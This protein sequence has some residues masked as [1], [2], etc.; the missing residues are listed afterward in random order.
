MNTK[1]S[2]A[3]RSASS[4]SPLLRRSDNP[5]QILQAGVVRKKWKHAIIRPLMKKP[6]LDPLGMAEQTISA[7][8]C[9]LPLPGKPMILW[10]RWQN[11]F[12]TYLLAIGG[13]KYSPVRKQAILLHHLGTE[14]R[15]IYDDLPEVSLGMVEGQP[16]NVYEMSLP[17]LEKHFTPKIIIVFEWHR[18]FSQV[19][20]L[21]EDIMTYVAALRGL[22]V[23]CDFRD[24]SDSL[25][26]D[27]HVRCMNNKKVKEKL[28]ATDPSLEESKHIARSMEHTEAWIKEIETKSYMKDSNKETTVEVKEFKAKKQEKPAESNA[29][30]VV[31]KKNSNIICFRCGCPGHMASSSMCAARNLTCRMCGRKGL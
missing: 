19:Q 3:E 22:A 6:H 2:A 10:K 8:P 12:T 26:H 15:R 23:T 11:I 31:E 7:P 18:F 28:L 25:I 14:G 21:D 5:T 13:D 16:M 1:R 27:Q 17:M 4:L 9:F 20:G 29:M 24:L 30:R